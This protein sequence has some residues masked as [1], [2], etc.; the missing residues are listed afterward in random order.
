MSNLLLGGL[1]SFIDNSPSMFHAANSVIQKLESE[2]FS[3]LDPATN[4]NLQEGGKYYVTS[5]H[6]AVIGF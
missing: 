5:N 6:S 1:L 3:Y 2:G 4:W